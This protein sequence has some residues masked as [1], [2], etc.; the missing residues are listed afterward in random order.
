MSSY[1]QGE[2]YSIVFDIWISGTMLSI[3][4]KQCI[5][6]IELKETVEGADS[7]T[8]VIADPEFLYI[9]DNIFLEDNKIKI[10]LG[11]SNS[12]YRENFNGY[13]SSVDIA[14]NSD[15]IPTLTVTCMDNTHRMNRKKHSTTYSKCTS[16]DVV[17][18]IAKK[19]GFSCVVDSSY[20]FKKQE[21]ITQSNQT[22][23]EF[24]TQL[25][26]NEV[27]PIT[28]RLVGNTL[29]YVKIGKLQTPKITLTYKKFPHEI[30]SFN[31][32][33]NK[34]SKQVEISGGSVNTSKKSTSKSKGTTSKTT[35]SSGSSGSS[36]SSA[37]SSNSGGGY[38][39]PS[40]SP[41]SKSSSGGYT[42][43]PT[44]GRWTHN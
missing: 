39:S 40:G 14:F 9:E 37:S 5:K 17:K 8:L 7:A 36:S 11:W 38:A 13:I 10:R 15:G 3:E 28:V 29:Y 19:Y 34:E 26:S 27:H 43:N 23:I 22:D 33:V 4:K 30:I 41:S 12:T 20:K 16:A 2:V 42:Y 25:A 18:K 32:R 31:P 6:Q 35:K 21:T 24:L 44:T 1:N